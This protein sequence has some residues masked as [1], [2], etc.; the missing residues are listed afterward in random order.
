MSQQSISLKKPRPDF[1]LTPRGDGRWQKKV[2]GKVH[3][4]RGTAQ[5]ALD[6]WL[7][8]KDD[9]LA[10]RDPRPE[11]GQLT[12]KALCN[13][14][15]EAKQNAVDSGELSVSSW[16]DY[17]ASCLHVANVFGRTRVVETLTAEDFAQLRAHLAK[18]RSPVT[19]SN[20]VGRIRCLFKYA[21]DYELIDMP[22]RGIQTAL[23]K[24]GKTVLRKVKAAQGAKLFTREQ[25]LGLLD[26]AGESQLKPMILLALG[27]GLGNTD[28]AYLTDEHITGEWLDYPRRKT[29]IR[30]RAHLW[31]ETLSAIA[32]AGGLPFRTKFGGKWVDEATSDNAL[33]KEFRKLLNRVGIKKR[34]LGFYTL[35]H[36]HRT[37]SDEV[38]DQPASNHVMGHGSGHMAAVYRERISDE[39]LRAISDYVRGW[40]FDGGRNDE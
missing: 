19:V 31:Q 7:R 23:K 39:R 20:E 11:T 18:G 13:A 35:R 8:V 3:Y 37:L 33:A 1:P 30:R 32:A 22:L 12:V 14:F 36:L 34:G 21:Y 4:F 27:C 28:I 38:G 9:L 40:L 5:D 16:R 10:G 17:K 15:L 25:V 2:R 24:P 26:G 6:E 29:G